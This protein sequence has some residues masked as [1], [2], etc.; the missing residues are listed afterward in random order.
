MN[1]PIPQSVSFPLSGVEGSLTSETLHWMK[2]TKKLKNGKTVAYGA[3]VGCKNGSRPYS[4]TFTAETGP[5]G[6]AA[7]G[8]RHRAPRSAAK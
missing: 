6:A 4:V 8:H 3:S 2:L 1:T 7:V 5:G